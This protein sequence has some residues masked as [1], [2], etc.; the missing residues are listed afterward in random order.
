MKIRATPTIAISG[1]M[2]FFFI[3][4]KDY[5]G[6]FVIFPGISI[7]EFLRVCNQFVRP[8]SCFGHWRDP[9][10]HPE[11]RLRLPVRAR[12]CSGCLPEPAGQGPLFPLATE[13][14]S[15]C[16]PVVTAR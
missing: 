4:S 11:G 13:G 12:N 14:L 10:P 5:Q 15:G 3:I 8:Y 1:R 16:S 7:V 9:A 6:W 2:D